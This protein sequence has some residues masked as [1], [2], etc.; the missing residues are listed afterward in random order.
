MFR[1]GNGAIFKRLPAWLDT[2]VHSVSIG[3]AQAEFSEGLLSNNRITQQPK[4]AL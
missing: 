4:E 1:H 2:I 3:R